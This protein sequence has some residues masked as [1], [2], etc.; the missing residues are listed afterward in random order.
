MKEASL[1]PKGQKAPSGF[2]NR[3]SGARDDFLSFVVSTKLGVT[4]G[5]ENWI[6]QIA[7]A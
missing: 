1:I 2:S 6:T 7:V 5:H 4:C 3:P